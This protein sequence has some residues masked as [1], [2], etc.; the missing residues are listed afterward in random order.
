MSAVVVP[1]IMTFPS[2]IVRCL[3]GNSFGKFVALDLPNPRRWTSPL[4]GRPG[5]RSSTLSIITPATSRMFAVLTCPDGAEKA[6]LR[7]T[8][9]STSDKNPVAGLYNYV[10]AGVGRCRT[11]CFGRRLSV[12]D[13]VCRCDSNITGDSYRGT[14][15]GCLFFSFF[16]HIIISMFYHLLSVTCCGMSS[17]LINKRRYTDSDWKLRIA[18]ECSCFFN[19]SMVE[20]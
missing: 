2:P 4:Q 8:S 18:L 11:I 1:P 9:Q 6:K 20:A 13:F 16:I 7:V 10:F 3:H 14:A 15:A 12:D 5:C 17:R 19:Q